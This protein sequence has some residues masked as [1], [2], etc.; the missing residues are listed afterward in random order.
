MKMVVDKWWT[1]E[2]LLSG[3]MD[4]GMRACAHEWEFGEANDQRID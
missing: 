3:C 2:D 1:L 4:E